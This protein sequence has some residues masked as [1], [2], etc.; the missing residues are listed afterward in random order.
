MKVVA[1]FRRIEPVEAHHIELKARGFDWIESLKMLATS[2]RMRCDCDTFVITCDDDLGVPSHVYSTEETSLMVWI[3]EVSLRY[4][5]SDDFDQNTV[6]V[7][8]DALILKPLDLFGGFDIAL[9]ARKELAKYDSQPLMNGLQFWPLEAKDKLVAFFSEALRIAR[10]LSDE[11]RKWGADT[12]PLLML[13]GPVIKGTHRR[14]DMTVRFFPWPMLL[15]IS[16]V[17]MK[18]IRVGKRVDAKGSVADF[19]YWKKL[20]MKEYFERTFA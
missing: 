13:L 14:G 18:K 11:Q 15:E 10:S 17:M 2:A 6:F 12:T 7:G 9:T 1:P 20:H 8:A 16:S 4:L 3:L 5:E 19:K